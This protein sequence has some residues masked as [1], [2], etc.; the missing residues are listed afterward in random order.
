MLRVD[1]LVVFMAM[2]SRLAALAPLAAFDSALDL[3]N[4]PPKLSPGLRISD[5][6]YSEPYLW[7]SKVG[8]VPCLVLI[9]ILIILTIAE[10]LPAARRNANTVSPVDPDIRSTV[11]PPDGRLVEPAEKSKGMSTFS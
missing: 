5:K 3:G 10:A 6:K 8:S 4:A 1:Y 2:I 7:K 9:D 11:Y